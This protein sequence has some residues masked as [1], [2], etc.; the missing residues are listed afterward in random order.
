MHLTFYFIYY[1]T[2]YGHDIQ[3][4]NNVITIYINTFCDASACVRTIWMRCVIVIY[5]EVVD[6]YCFIVVQR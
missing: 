4:C 1:V 2:K 6:Q 3:L 5:K